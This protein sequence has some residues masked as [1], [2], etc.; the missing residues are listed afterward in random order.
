VTVEA[1]CK[2]TESPTKVKMAML[3][4]FPDLDFVNENDVLIGRTQSVE[5]LGE[6]LRNQHIR[7]TAREVLLKGM[8]ENKTSFVL[9]KQAAFIGKVSFATRSPLGNIKVT[10]ENEDLI[11]LIDKIAPS[12]VK[13]KSG[14]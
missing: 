12:T 8:K 5:K 13:T 14:R 11:S 10:I 6:A 2:P 3:N 1:D 9:N 4:I 7:D